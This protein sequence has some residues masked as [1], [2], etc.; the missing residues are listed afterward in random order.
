ME[1]A[2]QAAIRPVVKIGDTVWFADRRN[3]RIVENLAKVVLVRDDGILTLQVVD[4]GAKQLHMNVS[5]WSGSDDKQM[6]GWWKV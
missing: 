2:T 3:G 1:A 6:F 5:K 4:Q